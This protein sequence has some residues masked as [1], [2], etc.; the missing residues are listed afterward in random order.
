MENTRPSEIL[1]GRVKFYTAAFYFTRPWVYIAWKVSKYGVFPSPYFPVFGLN[2]KIYGVDLRIQSEYRKIRTRK[3]SV[4]AHF[5]RSV[6]F[7]MYS[8]SFFQSCQK[9]FWQMILN[10]KSAAVKFLW[11]SKCNYFPIIWKETKI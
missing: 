10:C 3:N 1:H 2:T 6:T 8:L 5:P 4:S 7:L 9:W 11:S